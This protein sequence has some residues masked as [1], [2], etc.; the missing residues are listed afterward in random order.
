MSTEFDAALKDVDKSLSSM[1]ETSDNRLPAV[2]GA[3]LIVGGA[4]LQSA[5]LLALAIR[6]SKPHSGD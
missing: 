5:R 1:A 3:A 6:D 2:P 4:I